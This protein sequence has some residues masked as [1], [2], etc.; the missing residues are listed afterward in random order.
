MCQVRNLFGNNAKEGAIVFHAVK[1]VLKADCSVGQSGEAI[2]RGW[3]SRPVLM[4][5][6]TAGREPIQYA[7]SG[8]AT[9]VLIRPR[10]M[11]LPKI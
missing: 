9:T 11:A 10:P 2:R 5:S 3:S 1:P 4:P 7:C 8:F 6:A